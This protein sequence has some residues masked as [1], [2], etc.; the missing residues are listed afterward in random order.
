MKNDNTFQRI[1][2]LGTDY[3]ESIKNLCP[4]QYD[5]LKAQDEQ[6]EMI[7]DAEEQYFNDGDIETLIYFWENLHENGGL[8]FRSEYWNFRLVDLYLEHGD[9]EKASQ[10]LERLKGFREKYAEYKKRLNQ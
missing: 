9:L 10:F 7:N 5:L 2:T 3:L 1:L 6:V 4:N 8:I